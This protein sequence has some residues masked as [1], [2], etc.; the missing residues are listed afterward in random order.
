MLTEHMDGDEF[1]PWKM[2]LTGDPGMYYADSSFK[3][4]MTKPIELTVYFHT[5]AAMR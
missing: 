3:V 2:T 5:Y 1:A 4:S